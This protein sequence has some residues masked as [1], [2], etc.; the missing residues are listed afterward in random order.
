MPK[1]LPTWGAGKKITVETRH[2]YTMSL[3]NKGI[4]LLR[5]RRVVIVRG[6]ADLGHSLVTTHRRWTG[7]GGL[8]AGGAAAEQ[9]IAAM[10][11]RHLE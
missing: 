1:S 7:C 11:R 2:R 10:F 8:A 9:V 6:G 5:W 4:L 3:K